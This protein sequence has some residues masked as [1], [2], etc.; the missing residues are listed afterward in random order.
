MKSV[1]FNHFF[2]FVFSNNFCSNDP[3]LLTIDTKTLKS[4]FLYV[5][6]KTTLKT[7]VTEENIKTI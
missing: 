7:K 4:E 3:V 5:I 2:V 1:V 6:I